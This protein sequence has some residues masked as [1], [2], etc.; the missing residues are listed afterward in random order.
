[1]IIGYCSR[2]CRSLL[3]VFLKARFFKQIK[4]VGLAYTEHSQNY[5]LSELKTNY[6]D[7]SLGCK[8]GEICGC[9][10]FPLKTLFEPFLRPVRV[11]VVPAQAL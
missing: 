1:M 2:M 7:N 10:V 8:N 4:S 3:N 6:T 11:S 5:I 9:D